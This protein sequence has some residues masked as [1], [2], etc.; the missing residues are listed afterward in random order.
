MD[1]YLDGLSLLVTRPRE[2]AVALVRA[3]EAAGGTARVLPT[4]EIGPVADSLPLDAALASLTQYG[5]VIFVSANAVREALAR[6]AALGLP[7]LDRIALA[8]APGPAT[9]AALTASG[10]AEV[11]VPV[12]RFDSEGLI[13]ELSARDMRPARVLVLRGTDEEN[14]GGAGAGRED[15]VR[16]LRENGASVEVLA[17]YR[18]VYARLD[19]AELAS[20]TAG[21]APDA[22]LVTSSEGG[23]ALAAMIGNSGMAWIARVPMFVPHPRIA[24]AMGDLG[25]SSV[26]LTEGGDVGLMRGLAAHFGT[27]NA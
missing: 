11:V 24:R 23:R 26:H 20:M 18:R 22:T 25:F 2:Q 3:I 9:A 19:P 10:V 16:W 21:P 12:E 7:G 13:A 8:A 14:A 17:C 27:G 1:R 15:L 6:C 4:L 5:L